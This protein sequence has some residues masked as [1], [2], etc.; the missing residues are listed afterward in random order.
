MAGDQELLEQWEA[1]RVAEHVQ[2]LQDLGAEEAAQHL[3]AA[4]ALEQSDE[5]VR[6]SGVVARR[7]D[8]CRDE[9]VVRPRRA[10]I[11]LEQGP[12]P[13][14]MALGDTEESEV[15]A[16][17]RRLRVR[18]HRAEARD[19]PARA[20]QGRG[21]RVL[22]AF[23]F[24]D[25]KRHEMRLEERASTLQHG[26]EPPVELRQRGLQRLRMRS[27]GEGE[28]LPTQLIEVLIGP[29][30]LERRRVARGQE[31]FQGDGEPAEHRERGHPRETTP[32]AARGEGRS[33]R[34][35]VALLHTDLENRVEIVWARSPCP[36]RC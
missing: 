23:Q 2:G 17:K 16:R 20:D 13:G 36:P 33:S 32:P 21:C 8:R 19:A 1:G 31:A 6:V 15:A 24:G 5:Q 10:E 27:P 3:I 29:G 12:R 28:R 18:D 7:F 34:R 30:G 9:R 22:P 11:T 35:R 25:A 14:R 4:N 26:E